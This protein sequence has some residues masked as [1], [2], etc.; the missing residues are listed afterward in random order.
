MDRNARS[1]KKERINWNE[2][3]NNMVAEK[4]GTAKRNKEEGKRNEEKN[5]KCID[6]KDKPKRRSSNRKGKWKNK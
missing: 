3:E 4:N 1:W 5:R 2:V 6:H